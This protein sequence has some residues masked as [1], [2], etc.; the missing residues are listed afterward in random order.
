MTPFEK[1]NMKQ[2]H[3][4]GVDI[5]GTKMAIGVIDLISGKTVFKEIIPTLA[6]QGGAQILH[7]L[8]EKVRQI[9]EQAKY[10]GIDIYGLS[11]A[12]P[13]LVSNQ[14]TIDSTWN[15]DW[16]GVDLKSAF[17]EFKHVF[18]E[19]DVR[20]AANGEILFGRG[21]EWTNFVYISIGT[22]ISYT[23]CLNGKP[24]R[25]ANG[26]AVHFATSALASHC[27]TCGT[28][29]EFVVESFSSG[30]G[31]VENYNQRFQS[32]LKDTRDVFKTAESDKPSK[33]L[34]EQAATILGSLIGQM[35]NM[36]DPQAIVIG[37]GLGV[38]DHYFDLIEPQ[39]RNYIWEPTCKGLP[40]VKAHLKED[41][42]MIGAASL[43][44]TVIDFNR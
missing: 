43:A 10:Q 19:S 22:G 4:I 26:Y 11:I 40:I 6:D 14:E 42:G 23:L 34:I 8:K 21:K 9:N 37:G 13:E 3:S 12:V 32:T 44:R 30:K 16:Q 36:L 35:V 1:I 33:E 20:A 39:I 25:G 18:V 7:N 41:A 17:P 31:I 28:F 15:F 2:P 24:Y 29:N 27:H 38:S 5:G